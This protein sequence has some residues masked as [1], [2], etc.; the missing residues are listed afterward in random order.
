MLRAIDS[1]ACAKNAI[2]IVKQVFVSLFES[3]GLT[4]LL[5]RPGGTWMDSDV[6]MDQAP[7]VVLDHNKDVKQTKGRGYRNEEIAGN[8]SL[9]VQA[10]EVRRKNR[11]SARIDWLDRKASRSHRSASATRS[12]ADTYCGAQ[13]QVSLRMWLHVA[14]LR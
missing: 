14:I 12:R 4:Q 8:D 7:T 5:Q 11:F 6:A 3:D 2:A 10:Q 13:Q 1:A 9:S